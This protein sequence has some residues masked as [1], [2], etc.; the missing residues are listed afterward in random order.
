MICIVPV[1]ILILINDIV[2]SVVFQCVVVL[3]ASLRCRFSF[4]LFTQSAIKAI[5]MIKKEKTKTIHI[6]FLGE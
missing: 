6:V 1:F 3:K 5:V 2:Q 4:S